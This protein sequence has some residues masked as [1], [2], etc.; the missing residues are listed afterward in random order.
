MMKKVYYGG[1]MFLAL[2]LFT[3]CGANEEETETT[4]TEEEVTVIEG[5][6]EL[7]P[8]TDN[9]AWTGSWV[10]GSSDGNTHDGVISVTEGFVEVNGESYEGS[11]TIDMNSIVNLDLEEEEYNAKLV[12]H[13]KSDDFFNVEAFPTAEVE[14]SAVD[15]EEATVTVHAFGTSLTQTVPVKAT[16]TEE[17]VTL[18][19]SFAFDFEEVNMPGMQANP[20]AP[21]NGH[22]ATEI[23]FDLNLSLDK[24]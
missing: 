16:I 23:N 10:G 14:V 8:Q 24:K 4:T 21:E 20:E 13:L 1:I 12:G 9:L 17:N 2:G 5:R 6:Y 7:T 11:F 18:T 19:G 15:T 22:V 3:A